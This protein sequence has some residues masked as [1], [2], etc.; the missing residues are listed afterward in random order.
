ME[1]MVSDHIRAM[2]FLWLEVSDKPG[3]GSMRAYIETN[4]I[5]LISNYQASRSQQSPI[6][7]PSPSWLGHYSHLA[8]IRTSGLWN[9]RHIDETYEPTFL[10]VLRELVAQM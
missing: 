6:D 3:P 4:A 7:L 10:N 5:S 9:V 1:R 2:P 8:Q